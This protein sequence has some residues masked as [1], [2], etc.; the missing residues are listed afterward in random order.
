[1]N[2]LTKSEYWLL[3]LVCR[4]S[5][6]LHLLTHPDLE[7]IANRDS[8]GLSSSELL[9]TLHKL[10]QEGS[11]ICIKHPHDET[12]IEV[13]P[14]YQE[15]DTALAKQDS[16]QYKLTAKGGEQWELLS[17]PDWDWFI[18]DS[19]F[20]KE[21]TIEARYIQTAEQYIKIV[22]YFDGTEVIPKSIKSKILNPWQ[23][24]YWKILPEGYELSAQTRKSQQ[25]KLQRDMSSQ[26]REFINHVWNWYKNPFKEQA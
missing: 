19:Y 21:I 5:F 14:T 17:N 6:P 11:L 22:P 10:F 20:K 1:M 8:H 24:T 18:G 4:G 9:N 23:V 7:L 25:I 2:T 3:D 13:I 26:E 15:I 12:V 16:I